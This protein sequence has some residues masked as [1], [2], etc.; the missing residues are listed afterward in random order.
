MLHGG[1]GRRGERHGWDG[2]ARGDVAAIQGIR[3]RAWRARQGEQGS[4]LPWRGAEARARV[5]G[6]EQ[7]GVVARRRRTEEGKAAHGAGL[8]ATQERERDVGVRCW[9][10]ETGRPRG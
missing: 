5:G 7:G 3:G 10:G 2:S 8:A 4:A 9:A 1:P 6:A